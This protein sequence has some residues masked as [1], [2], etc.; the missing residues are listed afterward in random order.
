MRIG[1]ALALT[2][3]DVDFERTRLTVRR[4][5]RRTLSG[6]VLSAP[7]TAKGR[8]TIPLPAA[9]LASLRAQRAHVVSQ[10]FTSSLVFPNKLGKP[11]R[12]D[13]VMLDFKKMLRTAGL[14]E[15]RLHDLRHTY[16]TSL[17]ARD[18][19][20]KAAQELLGHARMEMTMDLYTGS[21][22]AVLRDAVGR[23]DDLFAPVAR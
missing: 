5:L 17:F 7:K 10:P 4:S 14:P 2:W 1:E 15:K 6:P 3:N 13:K 12:A 8:R 9:A 23:L 18:V 20:P 11:L 16:A 21:V 19:H 22:P